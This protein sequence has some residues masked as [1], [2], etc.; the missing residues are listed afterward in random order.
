MTIHPIKNV[1]KSEA[2]D[3][4]KLTPPEVVTTDAVLLLD[5]NRL[6][7]S[8]A[9]QAAKQAKQELFTRELIRTRRAGTLRLLAICL[10]IPIALVLLCGCVLLYKHVNHNKPEMSY[11]GRCGVDFHEVNLMIKDLELPPNGYFEQEVEIEKDVEIIRV[12]PLGKK[13]LPSVTIY[14][15]S[16]NYSTVE[17]EV[18]RLCYIMPMDKSAIQQPRNFLDTIDMTLKV[19]RMMEM[20]DTKYEVQVP[21]L[22]EEELK[23]Y[24]ERA[25]KACKNYRSFLLV[26]KNSS[27]KS[28]ES[29]PK[30]KKTIIK[31]EA[32]CPFQGLKYCKGVTKDGSLS[33][34]SIEGCT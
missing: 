9:S 6:E 27:Q 25:F 7:H 26:K 23:K 20:V 28:S 12:P 1:E 13:V 17:D 15:F 11:Y 14:D 8:L 32:P 31:R 19:F 5:T 16:A 34:F 18:N 30:S 24:G 22:T 29:S 10:L 21:Q 33:C 3:G 4:G 2:D